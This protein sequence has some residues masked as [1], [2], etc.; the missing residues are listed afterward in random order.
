MTHLD[1]VNVS[2]AARRTGVPR[3]TIRGWIDRDLLHP[4][5]LDRAGTPLYDLAKITDLA[6]TTPRRRRTRARKESR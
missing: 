4:A 3:G 1:L 5:G 2:E 6:A